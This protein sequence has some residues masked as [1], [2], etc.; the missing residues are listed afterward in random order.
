MGADTTVVFDGTGSG[1]VVAL[2]S[3]GGGGY[4]S[5]VSRGGIFLWRTTDGGRSFGRAQQ[6]YAGPGFQDHPWIAY[7]PSSPTSLFIAWTNR[8]GLE[9][10]VSR[11]GGA[12][13]SAPQLIVAGSA[14]STPVVTVG[15]AGIVHVFYEELSRPGRPIRLFVVSSADDGR[16]FARAG[17]I[18][19]APWPPITG[20]GPKG[21]TVT[22]PPLLGVAADPGTTRSAVA[23]SGQDPRAGHPVIYLW[24]NADASGTWRGPEHPLSGLAAAVSQVQPRLMYINHLLFISFFAIARSG[25]ITE[26]LVHQTAAGDFQPQALGTV[27]FRAAG[28]I[29]DYQALAGSGQTAYAL[30]ND[31]ESGRLEI[32]ARSFPA[33]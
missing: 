19:A 8:S 24:Q 20:A 31:A 16:S 22:P 10:V 13:F 1:Y 23:I 21:S 18:G 33:D 12:R 25:Q 6:V 3:H 28:F 14:P 29:G 17:L 30:W 7:S 32:V 2:L 27:P 9:F 5:R 26:Q 4:P 11:D 15:T